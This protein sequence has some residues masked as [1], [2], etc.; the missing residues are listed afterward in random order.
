MHNRFGYRCQVA[1][2]AVWRS[3]AHVPQLACD[4]LIYRHA[5][6]NYALIAKER[7]GVVSNHMALQVGVRSHDRAAVVSAFEPG[8]GNVLR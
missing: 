1:A 3:V 7:V 8:F 5:V 4:E 6:L 2:M